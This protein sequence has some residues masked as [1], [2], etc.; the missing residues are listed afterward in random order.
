[1]KTYVPIYDEFV[2]FEVTLTC[3]FMKLE[4]VDFYRHFVDIPY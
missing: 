2:H 1:M 4:T 3:M